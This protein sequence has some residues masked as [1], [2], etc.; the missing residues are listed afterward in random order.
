MDRRKMLAL[1][2]MSPTLVAG[3]PAYAGAAPK[4]VS[5]DSSRSGEGMTT[6]MNP[7]IAGKLATRVPLAPPLDTLQGKRIYMINLSWEGPDA[8][9]YL[10]QAMTEWFDKNYSGVK[11]V[12]K[13]TA[14]GMFGSDP[15]IVKD[16]MASKA[17]AVIVGVAG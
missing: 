5:E 1:L 9:N 6:V 10:Y 17:D 8:A 3:S 15:S 13:V 7:A 2:G 4:A 14:E 11:T 16:I 12:V